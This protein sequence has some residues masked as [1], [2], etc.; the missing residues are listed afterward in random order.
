M[1]I[2]KLTARVPIFPLLIVVSLLVGWFIPGFYAWTDSD[3][4]RPSP[5]LWQVPLFAAM[6]SMVFCMVLP[7]MPIRT[8]W[9]NDTPRRP[10]R[11]TVRT[12]LILTAGVAVMIP[13]AKSPLLAK[14][15]LVVSGIACAGALIYLIAFCVRNPQHRM[16]GF[17]LLGVMTLPYAWVLGY[18]ELDR[19]L[20]ALF[21]MIG[22]LPAFVPAALLGKLFGQHF[23]E[24]QWL[25]FLLTAVE[26]VIGVWMMRLGSKQ[27]VVYFLIVMQVSALGSLAFYMMSIA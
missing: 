13:L 3:Q 20:P 26:F 27:T 8:S 7:W 17:T 19:M 25:A 10:M 22:G 11:F 9:K 18:D 21:V 16:A 5:L 23:F 15:P 1:D 6:V 12:L 4:S 14:F 2:S 24:S